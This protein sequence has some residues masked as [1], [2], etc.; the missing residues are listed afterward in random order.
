MVNRPTWFLAPCGSY[1]MNPRPLFFL[2]IFFPFHLLVSQKIIEK[3]Y[4]NPEIGAV[5][6]DAAQFFE[7]SVETSAGDEMII[8]ATIDG[9]Y[10][11]DLLLRVTEEGHTIFVGSDF[12]PNFSNP[13]DKLSAHKVISIQVRMVLPRYKDVVI[14]GQ[15]CNVKV[16]GIYSD[17]SV[18][19]NDGQCI[20]YEVSE[21]ASVQT[22]SGNIF[23][24]TSKAKI[25][26]INKY[27]KIFK[28][29]IQVGDDHFLL[30][31]VTG[32][33]FLRKTE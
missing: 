28:D 2:F 21:S 3:T 4:V 15:S 11:K 13:N 20:L 25:R 8:E 22:Q 17:L 9:E 7:L 18:S 6:I 23:V 29:D 1:C 32:N 14:Y 24:H 12:Q 16:Q 5:N 19:L 33:I 31:T 30:N 26:S 27:G 10:R